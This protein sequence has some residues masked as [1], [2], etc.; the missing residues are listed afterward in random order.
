MVFWLADSNN[1]YGV[2]IAPNGF[3]AIDRV[4]NGKVLSPVSWRKATSL[5]TGANAVNSDSPDAERQLDLLL[6]Q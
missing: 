6:L 3:A 1:Y 2:Y 4:Q 5:K